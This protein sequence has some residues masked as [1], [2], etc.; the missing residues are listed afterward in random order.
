ML[1]FLSRATALR[2]CSPLAVPQP[3]LNLALKSELAFR[4]ASALSLGTLS[5]DPKLERAALH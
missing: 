3:E 2:L 4:P 1:P 5:L